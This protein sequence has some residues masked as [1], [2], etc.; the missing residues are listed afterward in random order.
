[1]RHRALAA[2]VLLVTRFNNGWPDPQ[3][4][5]KSS[6]LKHTRLIVAV[7]VLCTGLSATNTTKYFKEDHF[8][9]A[10]YIA[11]ASDGSYTV[12]AREHMGVWVEQSGR[13]SKS[14]TRITFSPKKSGASPY[15]AE[16]VTYK[17]RTF[18]SLVGDSGPSI[19][20]PIEEIERDLDKETQMLPPCLFFA[21]SAAVYERDIKLPYAFHHSLP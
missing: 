9:G 1:M 4:V 5:S 11:L 8:T 20:V 17:S 10:L 13:W 2:G 7:A 18:L 3:P 16:E 12:T 14:G 15:A 19:A 21:V 6:M